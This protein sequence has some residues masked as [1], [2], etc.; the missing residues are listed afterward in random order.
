MTAL[1][2]CLESLRWEEPLQSVGQEAPGD[3]A[4]PEA[5]VGDLAGLQQRFEIAIGQVL[6]LGCK[7]H[8][9]YEK[10]PK[11][12]QDEVTNGKFLLGR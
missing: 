9:L 8:S 7:E 10:H 3:G 1:A 6:A 4:L 12:G 5:E 11:E 2:E